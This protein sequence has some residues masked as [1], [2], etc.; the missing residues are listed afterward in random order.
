MTLS[1]GKSMAHAR[2]VALSIVIIAALISTIGTGG[3]SEEGENGPEAEARVVSA[4]DLGVLETTSQITARDGGYSAVFS[5]HSIWL[6]GDTFLSQPNEDNYG[7]IS[8]SWSFTTDI[9]ASDGITDFQEQVDSVGMPKAFL[10]MTNTEKSF[11]DLHNGDNCAEPPCYA[12]WALWP[13]AIVI[14]PDKNWAYVFY[15][16]IY[17]EPGDF[18]FKSVGQSIAVWKD[19]ADPAER[20][21]FSRVQDYPTLA[22]AEAEPAFGSA[23]MVVDT[24][25]YVYGCDLDSLAK[26]CRLA[27]VPLSDVLNLGAWEY[28]AGNSN[29]SPNL[30]DAKAVFKGNDIMSVLYSPY[31][32]RYL[33]IYSQ[34]LDK[35][36]ML[37]T[38]PS[39]EGPWSKAVKV[40]DATAPINNT[41]WVYDALAHPEYTAMGDNTIYIT[42]SRQTA[43]L[44]S[45]VRLVAVEIE[46]ISTGK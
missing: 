28:Y 19:F 18:N 35:Q 22:F 46:K 17:A 11:N 32:E 23:A 39:P 26:P 1:N 33:A 25:L 36:T 16:K 38:A 21:E 42:Y 43:L 6:Y 37:R 13:G 24:T 8:N 14:D 40:F 44:T 30:S 41:G 9:D 4:T 20:P 7:L 12:R 31:V 34:P 3:G 27:R 5:G 15:N 2:F 10:P 29:W 45:E